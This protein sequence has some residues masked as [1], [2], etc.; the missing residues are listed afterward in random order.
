[1]QVQAGRFGARMVKA[2][3][4]GCLLAV[5]ACSPIYRNHGYAPTDQDLEL[6]EIGKDD[7]ESV[8]DIIG[9]PSAQNLLND[10]SWYYVQS[11]W[12]Q[13]GYKPAVEEERQ[14]VAVSFDSRGLVEN[15]E[16][17]GL[18]DGQVVALS[19]RVTDSNI[20][21]VGFLRQLMGNFGRIDPTTLFR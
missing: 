21:G 11:R 1:M 16:R 8:A 14:V 6:I 9:R 15:V 19:R 12:R 18:E 10:E 2:L 20:K 13:Y 5:M 3:V 7:R 17:F 4:V